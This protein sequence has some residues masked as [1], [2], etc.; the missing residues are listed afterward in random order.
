MKYKL[1]VYKNNIYYRCFE[2][3]KYKKILFSIA[4]MYTK[5]SWYNCFIDE[6]TYNKII[7]RTWNITNKGI[8]LDFSL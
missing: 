8:S 1:T 2:Y 4:K 7:R 6:L 3:N 5:Y